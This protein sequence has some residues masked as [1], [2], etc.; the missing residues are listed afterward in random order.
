M[1]K[2]IIVIIAAL[3]FSVAAVAQPKAIGVR[4]GWDAGV[5][6]QHYLGGENFLE[7]NASL[8]GFSDSEK[9]SIQLLPGETLRL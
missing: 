7:A 3:A 4:G 8:Y 5:S 6:Y 9:S 2:V 1:R